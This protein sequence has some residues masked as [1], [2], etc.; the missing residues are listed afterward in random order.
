MFKKFKKK[1]KK[2]QDIEKEIVQ[3]M[4]KQEKV[5]QPE[6]IPVVPVVPE[7]KLVEPENALPETSF[8][9]LTQKMKDAAKRA[10]WKDLMPV[11]SRAIPYMLAR[12][13]L[14][15]QSRTGS[16]KTGAFILPALDR[17]HP[18]KPGC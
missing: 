8:A 9:K 4:P 2:S 16:G 12:R 10:G 14:M 11:Q 7:D 18:E 5:L 3:E 6:K 15:V 13:D 17:I 1:S